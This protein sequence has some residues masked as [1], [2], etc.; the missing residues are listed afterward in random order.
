MDRYLIYLS[1]LI[2]DYCIQQDDTDKGKRAACQSFFFSCDWHS[3]CLVWKC[4]TKENI[5]LPRCICIKCRKSE[6]NYHELAYSQRRVTAAESSLEEITKQHKQILNWNIHQRLCSFYCF[7]FLAKFMIQRYHSFSN[8]LM[9]NDWNTADMV[10]L[11][12]CSPDYYY[13]IYVNI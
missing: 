5:S 11:V 4:K 13:T 8:F 10:L 12:K 6:N 9:L 1:A 2:T 3:I 7:H